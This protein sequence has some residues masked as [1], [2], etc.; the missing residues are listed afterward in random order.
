MTLAFYL[1]ALYGYKVGMLTA[2]S[3]GGEDL[4]PSVTLIK[5]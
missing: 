1:E 5:I 3:I 4:A 2:E